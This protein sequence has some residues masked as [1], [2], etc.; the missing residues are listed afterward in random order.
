[1]KDAVEESEYGEK[2]KLHFPRRGGGLGNQA[3]PPHMAGDFKWKDYAP[4]VFRRLRDAFGIDPADYLISLS[5]NHA[6]RELASPGKSGSIFYI[7]HDDRY[8]I[9]A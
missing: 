5:M 3:T 2:V 4:M 8:S 7:S 9:V 1:M 6:L